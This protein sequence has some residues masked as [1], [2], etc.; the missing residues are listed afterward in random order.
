[1]MDEGLDHGS[2][3]E[4]LTDTLFNLNHVGSD[5]DWNV[6]K[7]VDLSVTGYTCPSLNG[8]DYRLELRFYIYESLDGECSSAGAAGCADVR[9]KVQY[10]GEDHAEGH[11]AYIKLR[12]E[13]IAGSANH[14]VGHA[15]GLCNGGVGPH[16]NSFG[17]C[18]DWDQ[19]YEC[20]VSVM[21]SYGCQAPDDVQMVDIHTVEVLGYYSTGQGGMSGGGGKAFG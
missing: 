12:P 19:D 17:E 3:A 5:L 9:D 2:V 14:E 8:T 4:T 7:A 1:M 20:T 11:F 16:G 18:D 13:T 6:G 15:F 21:H 10:S